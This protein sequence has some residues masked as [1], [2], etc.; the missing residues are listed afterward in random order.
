[1][2]E[3]TGNEFSVNFTRS[4]ILKPECKVK[5]LYY[6]W[7]PRGLGGHV[8]ENFGSAVLDKPE[9]SKSVALC[10]DFDGRVAGTRMYQGRKAVWHSDAPL[11]V[12]RKCFM[13]KGQSVRLELPGSGRM[14]RQFF[15]RGMLK[16]GVKYRLSF[17]LKTE[18]VVNR[19]N[20]RKGVTMDIRFGRESAIGNVLFP[21]VPAVIGSM[22]WNRFQYDFT[23]PEGVG[24]KQSPYIGFYLP[25]EAEGK[26]WIDHVE[27]VP[28]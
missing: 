12:D 19:K 8:P 28:L 27:I 21:L 16:A 6:S 11:N 4:R 2:P 20:P 25:K 26:V 10:G 13:T 9:K 7:F 17:Y 15:A 14:I 24:E 1:M 23:V 5:N 18:N 22:D 3:I